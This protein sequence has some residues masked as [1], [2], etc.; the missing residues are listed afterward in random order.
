MGI[1]Q[2]SFGDILHKTKIVID[3]DE[4]I[5]VAATNIDRAKGG[6]I[7]P[8]RCNRPFMYFV[9]DKVSGFVMFLGVYNSP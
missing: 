7:T 5:A 8:F 9:Y 3:E 4:A 1:N 2:T 6:K